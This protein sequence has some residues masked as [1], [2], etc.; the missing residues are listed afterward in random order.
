MTRLSV[1][2]AA[3]LT[4]VARGGLPELQELARYGWVENLR[5]DGP[6][7]LAD[8]TAAGLDQVTPS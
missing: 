7:W 5:E 8:V 6:Y 4:G 1:L 3:A 2:R